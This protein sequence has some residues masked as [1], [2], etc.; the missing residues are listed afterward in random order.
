MAPQQQQDSSTNTT[1]DNQKA[2]FYMLL[3]SL[4]FAFQPLLT[5]QF[6]PQNICRS[7]II[8]CQE[9][10]KF[11]LA[12]L[13]L[14]ISGNRTTA[15]T[16]WTVTSW[17]TVAFLPAALYALQNIAALQAYQNLDA[18]TFNV[19]N[20]TKTLSAAL[21]CYLVMGRKQSYL[22]VVSLLLLLLSALIMEKL[23]TVDL[24]LGSS[25][26]TPSLQL[27]EWGSKH[28]THGVAPIM[29][30]SFISGLSGALSQR[31][32]QAKG[33]GRNPYLF[34]ME[35]CAASSLILLCS[36]IAS[37]DGQQ[38]AQDG[39]WNGWTASTW[40]PIFT[41]SV[42]GIIVGL[43]TKYAGSV[44]K[45]FALILGMFLSG[46]VQALVTEEGVSIEQGIGGALAAV[47]LWMHATNPPVLK[48][49]VD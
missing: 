22:Q 18:L 19:L 32:L 35:L 15:L 30:A 13:M 37:P 43:V 41:N 47:S 34:S 42:G 45:G 33:G 4:Q 16:G 6:T 36:L 25:S 49:K 29:L 27:P 1:A 9:L 31:N 26:S 21:C 39:F 46:I 28:W 38:I 11:L 40:I 7:T 23:V 12:L 10:L 3:L 20:Q 14:S 5:R 2:I 44:R 24:F 17:V 8:L 48:A